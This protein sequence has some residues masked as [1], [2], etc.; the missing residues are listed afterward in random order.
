MPEQEAPAQEQDKPAQPAPPETQ[1]KG[2]VEPA[3]PKAEP[4]SDTF[5]PASLPEELLPAYKQLQGAATRKFQEAAALRQPEAVAEYLRTLAPEVQEAVLERIGIQLESGED[6]YEEDEFPDPD[7][8]I[9]RRLEAIEQRFQEQETGQQDEQLEDWVVGQI[10]SQLED[11]ET[12][13]GREFS[14]AEAHTMGQ[15]A[16]DRSLASGKPP[17]MKA[18]YETIYTELLPAERKRWVSSKRSPQAPSGASG[19]HEPDL[20]KPSDRREYLAQRMRDIQD[21]A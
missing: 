2:T 11:L 15:M 7:E 16:F 18:V 10:G 4:F 14:D 20:D 21:T 17:D 6:L 3:A 12:A 19:S 9:S 5:D 8:E 13:T 1:D